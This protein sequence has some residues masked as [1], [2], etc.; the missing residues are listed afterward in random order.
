MDTA[1]RRETDEVERNTEL[2]QQTMQHILDHPEQHNQG[3]WVKV[4]SCGTAACFAGWAGLLSGMTADEIYCSASVF[5]DIGVKLLGLNNPSECV[6]LFAADNTIPMLELMVKDLVNGDELKPWS[7]YD[8]MVR[9]N[10]P[11]V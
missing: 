4:N 2:L 7:H 5:G 9:D 3:S 10:V 11:N 8:D 1:M 6:T